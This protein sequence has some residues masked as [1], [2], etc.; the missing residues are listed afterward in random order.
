MAGVIEPVPDPDLA[1]VFM[2]KVN[3]MNNEAP[4]VALIV[5]TAW[6]A[7]PQDTAL[8]LAWASAFLSSLY[9]V[10]DKVPKEV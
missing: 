7:L 5:A 2:E 10:R 1:R 3:D 6:S 8:S 4:L 9:F